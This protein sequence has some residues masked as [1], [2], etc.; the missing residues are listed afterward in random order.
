[1]M[2]TEDLKIRLHQKCLDFIEAK[3]AG[4]QEILASIAD[5]K[6]KETKSSAGDKF[7]TGRAM[8]QIEE[9]NHGRQLVQF[10]ATKETLDQ[11]GRRVTNQVIGSGNLIRTEKRRYYISA[12]IGKITLDKVDYFCISAESPIGQ[13]LIGRQ[14]GDEI[15]FNKVSDKILEVL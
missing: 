14:V 2:L 9:E 6:S 4:V 7:E 1:M 3:I 8:L 10:Y 15:V 12:G 13:L 11:V 5:A